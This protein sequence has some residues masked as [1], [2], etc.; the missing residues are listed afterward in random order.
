MFRL[1]ILPACLLLHIYM[2]SAADLV[3]LDG[4]KE[5]GQKWLDRFPGGVSAGATLARDGGGWILSGTN[6]KDMWGRVYQ[7]LELDLTRYPDLQVTVTSVTRQGYVLVNSGG[8]QG[9]FMRVADIDKAGMI[10]V[11][12]SA[13]TGLIGKQKIQLEIGVTDEGA[14]DN[15]KAKMGLSDIR[16]PDSQAGADEPASSPGPSGRT[17]LY[18]REARDARAFQDKWGD[19]SSGAKVEVLENGNLKI[20]GTKPDDVWGCVYAEIP[21]R[22]EAAAELVMEIETITGEGYIILKHADLPE[23]FLRLAPSPQKRGTHRYTLKD[24][25]KGKQTVEVQ[26]GVVNPAGPDATGASMEISGIEIIEQGVA[27]PT[28]EVRE[29]RA[30]VLISPDRAAD[31]AGEWL[32]KWGDA[33]SGASASVK[34]G[35]VVISGTRKNENWGC[36]YR[37]VEIPFDEDPVL[38]VDAASVTG[39]AYV[40][41]KGDGVPEGYVRLK[42]LPAAAGVYRYT[43]ADVIPDTRA[44][45]LELQLGVV[46]PGAATA[47]GAEWAVRR[48]EIVLKKKRQTEIE[49]MV[50]VNAGKVQSRGALPRDAG[51]A[52]QT[53]SPFPEIPPTPKQRQGR[54]PAVKRAPVPDTNTLTLDAG[55]MALT[56]TRDGRYAVRPAGDTEA[57]IV[58]GPLWTG[59]AERRILIRSEEIPIRTFSKLRPDRIRIEQVS[60]TITVVLD[61]TADK[62]GWMEWGLSVRS[63]TDIFL[64]EITFPGTVHFLISRLT[65]VYYPKGVGLYIQ[66]GFFKEQREFSAAK[67]VKV[68]PLFSDFVRIESSAGDVAVYAVQDTEDLYPSMLELGSRDEYGLYHHKMPAALKAGAPVR[69]PRV[70]FDFRAGPLETVY[71]RYA[72]A[73]RLLADGSRLD[74]KIPADRWD[75]FARSLMLKVDFWNF[76]RFAAVERR[77]PELPVRALVHLVAFWPD[78]FDRHYPDYLPPEKKFGTLEDF[79]SL[80]SSIRKSGRLAMPYTN[81]TW[82]N[83]SPTMT[84][85]G[86]EN[87]A[88]HKR[89]GGPA[90]DWYGTNRGWI[91]SPRL[92]AVHDRRMRTLDEFTETVPSDILFEDQLAAR[93]FQ[94]DWN[95]AAPGPMS[96]L[97]GMRDIARE[98]AGRIPVMTEGA[99]DAL[100]PYEI[101]FC[102]VIGPLGPK[103]RPPRVGGYDRFFGPGNWRFYPGMLFWANSRVRSYPHNLAPASFL[104]SL[105]QLAWSLVFSHGLI[106]E[107]TPAKLES[108]KV[109]RSIAAKFS[110]RAALHTVGQDLRRYEELPDGLALADY[111]NAVVRANFTEDDASAGDWRIGPDGF[112]FQTRDRRLLAGAV[113]GVSGIRLSNPAVFILESAGAGEWSLYVAHLFNSVNVV[114]LPENRNPLAPAL[115]PSSSPIFQNGSLVLLNADF[116]EYS[117]WSAGAGPEPAIRAIQPTVPPGGEIEIE[118]TTPAGRASVIEA[119][120]AHVSGQGPFDPRRWPADPVLRKELSGPERIGLAVPED[121]PPGSFLLM[122]ASLDGREAQHLFW[123]VALPPDRDDRKRGARPAEAP[124]PLRRMNFSGMNTVLAGE[125]VLGRIELKS[126]SDT[127]LSGAVRATLAVPGSDPVWIQEFR[128]DLPGNARKHIP[129][130]IAEPPAGRYVLDMVFKTQAVEFRRREPVVVF[131]PGEVVHVSADVDD[132]GETDEVIANSRL[133]AVWARSIGGRLMDLVL[134]ETRRSQLYRAYPEALRPDS[135]EDWS[136]YGGANDWF[137]RG[138]PGSVWNNDWEFKVLESSASIVRLSAET[139]LEEGLDLQREMILRPGSDQLEVQYAVSNHGLKPNSFIWSGHPDAAPGGE[140]GPEDE[141]VSDTLVISFRA[142]LTKDQF[143]PTSGAIQARDRK[144]GEFV[145]IA[146]PLNETAWIGMWHGRNF[147]SAEPIFHEIPLNPGES[148]RFSIGYRV[149]IAK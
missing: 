36:V 47:V 27:E 66:P 88:I 2:A 16:L 96:Y 26:F 89:S 121:V 37:N 137:P 56:I 48:M 42:P 81:P 94:I 132:D 10:R 112:L 58:S 6:T 24:I 148:R 123:Q 122:K 63:E 118:V 92:K 61:V 7:E 145:E 102:N 125:P 33:S 14:R 140:A 20:R 49:S 103:D 60:D 69:L 127:Q 131:S 18:S 38:V 110:S 95:P 67:E 44:R 114:R 84:A 115:S 75:T 78:G 68:P 45:S 113:T 35:K 41:L 146:Y 34:D 15:L 40:I 100:V 3:L 32:D 19:V 129:V 79:Q 109:W 50:P 13:K 120:L 133:E 124:S 128:V 134:R 12:L 141:L 86:P 80:N 111:G 119:Y 149:G 82:W 8:I 62:E 97:S 70:R 51:A 25:L 90:E 87:A 4:T 72:A 143:R 9:G 105:Q 17:A 138:W 130:E 71:R 29:T 147:F 99:W 1:A 91:I 73:N 22:F 142:D 126:G 101:G 30:L 28:T 52:G 64:P 46:N 43:L 57:P 107:I 53:S 54:I 59:L 76:D 116:P 108:D 135:P 39:E 85:L 21:V 55:I 31:Q 144:T 77:L 136:E 139:R 5:S 74:R 23:G 117:S 104:E 11:A 98:K 65:R 93:E 83:E 106:S